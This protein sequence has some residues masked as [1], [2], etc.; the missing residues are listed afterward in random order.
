M[1]ISYILNVLGEER[2]AYWQ[3]AVPPIAMTA[4]FAFPNIAAMRAA[5]SDEYRLP[6]Y[7]RGTNPTIDQFNRKMAA[8]ENTEAALSFA[9]GAAAVATAIMANVSQGDHIVSVDRP[10]SWTNKLLNVL[11]PRF[12]VTTT[13]V[14]GTKADNFKEA[15]RANTKIIFLESPN[16][17][18]FELQDVAA[19]AGIAKKHGLLTVMDNSYATPVNM[20][21]ADLGVDLIAHAAT[22]YICGHSDALAGVLCGTEAMMRKIF[23][24][25]FM[26]FGGVLSP[27]N[28]WL[29]LRGL[30]TLDLRMERVSATA[31][32][33]A[34]F[35]E[36]HPKVEKVYF[37]FLP[38]HPQ[39]ELA[40]AQMKRSGGL[41][42]FMLKTDDREKVVK[43]CES[44]ER[45]LIA[46]SWGGHESLVFP[47]CGIPA[48]AGVKDYYPFNLVRIYT[49]LEAPEVLIADLEQALRHL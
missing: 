31:M 5:F 18:T 16:S 12:G 42:S 20:R 40:K 1:D 21:P 38:S 36:Q 9:S 15:I 28:A 43:C 44:L 39:H 10:Y 30:R 41:M 3:A 6:V 8:L 49:G 19:V 7:T 23:S 14:D 26:A 27:F 33:V 11:L 48:Y 46:A 35:L 32:Q 34:A 45:F 4:N 25:E 17:F 24:S 22:K 47:A 2:E 37:P 29:M 13:M